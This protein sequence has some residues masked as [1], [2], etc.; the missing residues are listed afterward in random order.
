MGKPLKKWKASYDRNRKYNN[1]WEET[2]V[3]V[4]KA[5]DGSESAYC[6]LC[7]STI[8]PR[9]SNL[10]NHEKS[11]KHRRRI[12]STDQAHLNA[13]T[14]ISRQQYNYI[15][16]TVDVSMKNISTFILYFSLN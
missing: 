12:P 4:Q 13:V 14:E 15:V 5:A 9:I 6:K 3:W 11:E 16:N 1:K 8:L 2:F 7:H 10:S